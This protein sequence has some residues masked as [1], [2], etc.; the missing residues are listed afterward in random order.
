MKRIAQ[1]VILWL[2]E[3]A[4][5]IRASFNEELVVKRKS[6]P[7]DLV[8]NMD[9][10]VQEF[11]VNKIKATFPA[12]QLLGEEDA[13]K[14]EH[15][16]VGRVWII[17]PID[18][19]LNFVLQKKNFCIM[20]ALFED[21]VSQLG[22]IYDVTAD[23]LYWGGRTIGLFCND[24]P[25]AAPKEM[26]LHE[27]LLGMNAYLFS[28]NLQNAQAL[29]KKSAGVRMMGCAGLEMIAII[30]GMQVGY[31]SN[32]YP[33]DYAAGCA[34]LDAVNIPYARA[35]GK[36]LQLN[37]REPFLALSRPAFLEATAEFFEK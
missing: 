3:A 11:L 17:D 35:D 19:T 29:G 36:P 26:A 18:G 33:W 2:H 31:L 1:T 32:L 7:N 28:K 25:L 22:F 13:L 21:G 24:A 30:S 5:L 9:H 37:G 14:A 10:T 16:T 4:A 15:P 23:L 12:D 34:L 27:G 6:G 20:V 8:T